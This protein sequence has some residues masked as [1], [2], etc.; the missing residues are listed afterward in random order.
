M[1]SVS[2]D[3]PCAAPFGTFSNSIHAFEQIAQLGARGAMAQESLYVGYELGHRPAMTW[4]V[5]VDGFR[6][7]H[8]L[9]YL[10]TD[11]WAKRGDRPPVCW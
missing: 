5:V 3:W 9:G 11:F 1:P 2:L 6:R 7:T 10:F 8:R 4:Q